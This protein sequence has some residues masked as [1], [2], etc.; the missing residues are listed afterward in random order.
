MGWCRA[1]RLRIFGLANTKGER[2]PWSGWLTVIEVFSFVIM[3]KKRRHQAAKMPRVRCRTR[4]STPSSMWPEALRVV[5]YQKYWWLTVRRHV[6]S[7]GD[8]G[9]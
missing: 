2:G 1:G 5:W 3:V 4:S 6:R 7:G 8:A 9:A